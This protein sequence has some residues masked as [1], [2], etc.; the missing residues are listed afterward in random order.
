MESKDRRESDAEGKI[1]EERK[2]KRSRD[3]KRL[4]RRKTESDDLKE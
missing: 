2:R 1:G 3:D 4:R